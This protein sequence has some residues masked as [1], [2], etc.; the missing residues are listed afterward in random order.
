MPATPLTQGTRAGRLGRVVI[1]LLAALVVATLA[2]QA[3]A[4]PSAIVYYGPTLAPALDQY[5][6]PGNVIVVT[7]DQR[8]W[9]PAKLREWRSKGAIVMAYVNAVDW[10]PPWSPLQQRLYG[11]AFPSQWLYQGLSNYP[12]TKLLD[13]SASSPVATYN[14]FTGTWGQYVAQYIRNEVIGDGSLFNGVFLDAWG[15]RMWGA[16]IGG[17]GTDWEAGVARW[18]QA[19]RDAVG[20]T[21]F[22]VGN[23]TQ[24]LA[25]APPLN[26][27]MWE[28]FESRRAGYNDLTGTGPYPGLLISMTWPWHQPEL[29]ILWRNEA[30]PPQDVKDMLNAAALQGTQTGTD[31]A[32]GSSDHFFGIPAPFGA[33][34]G[35]AAP[36]P[37]AGSGGGSIPPGNLTLNPSFETDGSGWLSYQGTLARTPLADAPHGAQAMRV[38]QAAGSLYTLDDYPST[39]PQ[40][41]AGASYSATAWVKAASPS[42]VG[43]RICLYIRERTAALDF[44]ELNEACLQLTTTFAPLSVTATT[45]QASEVLDLVVTQYGAASGDSFYVDLVSMVAGT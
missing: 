25:T 20:P 38:T 13:L 24:T 7:A 22:L 37:V 40:A 27:R 10:H 14:G 11:G 5:A 28:S 12:G 45:Q 1:G 21:I 23:G 18:G 8:N 9:N 4:I 30:N 41:P 43:K 26:G 32:V 39:V 19:I 16:G 2:A 6:R 44:L 33:G 31:I 3:Q 29:M 35:T 17:P 42:A 34:G 15:A 36:P